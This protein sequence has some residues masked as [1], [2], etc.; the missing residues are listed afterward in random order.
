MNQT[1][2]ARRNLQKIDEEEAIM[3]R[4]MLDYSVLYLTGD[5]LGIQDLDI[6]LD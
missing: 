4:K 2:I 3:I 1:I 6:K 5:V